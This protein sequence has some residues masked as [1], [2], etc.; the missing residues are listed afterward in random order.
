MINPPTLTANSLPLKLELEFLLQFSWTY[1]GGF[2]FL[3]HN[4]SSS[5][6]GE[7]LFQGM[8]RNL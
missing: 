1:N 5:A 4:L 7:I 6:P 2:N 8:L 3:F